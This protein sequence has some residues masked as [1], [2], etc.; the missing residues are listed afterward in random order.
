MIGM[1]MLNMRFFALV[2]DVIKAFL[3]PA[4]LGKQRLQ[5]NQSVCYNVKRITDWQ[6][7][8]NVS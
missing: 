7:L 2:D 3:T 4:I 5:M 8:I 1:P 6:S